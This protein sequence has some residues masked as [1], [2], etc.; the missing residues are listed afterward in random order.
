MLSLTT[1]GVFALASIVLALIPGPDMLYI[2][3]RSVAQGRSAGVVSALGVH[4]GVLIHTLAAALGL[5]ALIAASAVA[6]SVV[7]FAGA[8]YLVVLGIK[9]LVSKSESFDVKVTSKA[10]LGEI[11]YQGLVTNV[12]NPKVILFFL[13]FLPQF[14][15]PARGSV[16][17]QLLQLGLLLFIVTLPI[18]ISVGLAGGAVGAWLSARSHMQAASKWFTGAVFIA[19]GIGT[20]LHGSRKL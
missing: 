15:D 5:S 7:K 14:V 16:S 1:V 18:D 13:A 19:L 2:A 20:A 10:K 11:F 4:A 17:L 12:L 6:F 3:T 9:T 8:A